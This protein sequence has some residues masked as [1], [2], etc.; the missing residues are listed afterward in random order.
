MNEETAKKPAQRTLGDKLKNETTA[1]EAMKKKL[2][3]GKKDN[4]ITKEEAKANAKIKRQGR[5]KAY[6]EIAAKDAVRRSAVNSD[7]YNEDENVGTES[8]EV[9][10][11]LALTAANVVES[12]IKA[13][14]YSKKMHE[15]RETD[16]KKEDIKKHDGS[17]PQSKAMQRNRMKK[18]IQENAHRKQAKE[19]TNQIGNLGRKFVDQAEDLMGKLAEFVKEHPKEIFIACLILLILLVMSACL[20]SCSAV[21]GSLSNSSV[22]TSYTSQD[23]DILAVDRAYTQL[24]TDLQNEVNSVE[25]NYPGYDEYRYDLANIG[26]NQYQLAALL[27]VLYEDY[28]LAEVQQMLNTIFDAQYDLTYQRI[29]ERRSREETRIGT[30]TVTH[31]DG[32]TSTETYTYTVTVYYDYYILKTTLK[33]YTM[34]AVVNGMNLSVDQMQRYQ[35]LL[36]TCGNKAYLWGDDIYSTVDPGDYQDYDIPPEVLTDTKF[37]N[38][39]REGEK[40]L[41]YPYVWGGSSPS[42]S[43]DCSGFVSYVINHCGNGWNVGRQTANGLL[44]KCTVVSPSEAKPG[45]L[46]FF[47]GT[48]DTSGASHVGIY[49]GNGMML[50]CGNPIQYTSINTNYWIQHFYC[51]GRIN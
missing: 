7:N 38:M 3:H 15:R 18:E 30:R 29:V 11:D 6:K 41:G 40:Y 27:T 46:I 43:F 35:I 4:R 12:K 42:T 31:E 50:H 51:Y 26:H 10:I 8:L 25:T 32:T 13:S 34:D 9:G 36:E 19:A 28:T 1:G 37:A 22:A 20:S 2:R 45:D 49:V 21:M 14:H 5:K 33:N 39:I 17:N 44:G 47:Q 24:E 23:S 48:Y 16:F